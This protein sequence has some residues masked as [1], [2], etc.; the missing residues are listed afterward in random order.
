MAGNHEYNTANDFMLF[1]ESFELYNLTNANIS[2]LDLGS[3]SFMMAEPYG[4]LFEEASKSEMMKSFKK[5][6]DKASK[7]K[8]LIVASHYP[9]ACSG[10]STHCKN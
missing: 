10:S 1:N 7:S 5:A 8:P 6:M 2:V 3:F 9:L 4:V